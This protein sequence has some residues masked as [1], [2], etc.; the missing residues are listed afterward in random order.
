MSVYVY[1]LTIVLVLKSPTTTTT[2][3]TATAATKTRFMRTI[4]A[5]MEFIVW[6]V[7]STCH[8]SIVILQ[9][10]VATLFYYGLMP[11]GWLLALLLPLSFSARTFAGPFCCVHFTHLSWKLRSL[12]F[13]IGEQKNISQ[14]RNPVICLTLL[15]WLCDFCV[16]VWVFSVDDRKLCKLCERIVCVWLK[17]HNACCGW[18]QNHFAPQLALFLWVSSFR[19]FLF[20]WFRSL[21]YLIFL[22]VIQF[23]VS[24]R[25]ISVCCSFFSHNKPRQ[26]VSL[27]KL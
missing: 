20:V 19:A 10:Y 9:Y 25:K 2:T 22:F 24:H 8:H 26:H 11:G 14:S 17:P 7:G 4:F 5:E 12:D 16:C 27:L 6:P 18:Y 23:V 15:F 1:Q 21:F 3:T 13:Y